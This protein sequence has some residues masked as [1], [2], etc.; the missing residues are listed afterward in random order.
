MCV[1]TWASFCCEGCVGGDRFGM[2]VSCQGIWQHGGAGGLSV[3]RQPAPAAARRFWTAGRPSTGPRGI[4]VR[5]VPYY[6]YIR[7]PLLCP[8]SGHQTGTCVQLAKCVSRACV[9]QL[10]VGRKAAAS[11]LLRRA[12]SQSVKLWL[13]ALQTELAS[14]RLNTR[15]A[16]PHASQPQTRGSKEM[17]T[18]SLA[19]FLELLLRHLSL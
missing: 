7:L 6:F 1:F 8:E 11:L 18:C 14:E 4:G 13:R 19:E 9:C 17:A 15:R 12:C 10:I 2:V 3:C 5:A 16:P